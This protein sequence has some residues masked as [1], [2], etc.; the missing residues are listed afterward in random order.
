MVSALARTVGKDVFDDES[1]L[2]EARLLR[3][4]AG[5]RNQY[6]ENVAGAVTGLLVSVVTGAITG[7]DRQSVPE[8]VRVE[9]VRSF[10]LREAVVAAVE[11][12]AGHDGD[13]IEYAGALWQ[14]RMVEDWGGFYAAIAVRQGTAP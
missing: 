10:W 1:L 11:G 9:D 5:D 7:T 13:R 12:V 14:V 4:G 2:E 8:G 3:Q 6:G